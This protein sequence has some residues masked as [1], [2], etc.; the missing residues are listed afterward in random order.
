M[1]FCLNVWEL[2]AA[3]VFHSC[4]TQYNQNSVLTM[5]WSAWGGGPGPPPQTSLGYGPGI[6]CVSHPL[7]QILGSV[8]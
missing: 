1:V 7:V 2:L 6:L 3:Y 5:P 4:S 8:S